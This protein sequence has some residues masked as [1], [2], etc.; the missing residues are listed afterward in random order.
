MNKCIIKQQFKPSSAIRHLRALDAIR[1]WIKVVVMYRYFVK[2]LLEN[3]GLGCRQNVQIHP[4][5][6]F[7]WPLFTFLIPLLLMFF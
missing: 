3:K 2:R 1:C 6:V 4:M 7:T 5:Y